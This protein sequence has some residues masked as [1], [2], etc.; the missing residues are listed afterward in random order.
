MFGLIV[1]AAFYPFIMTLS[2][3]SYMSLLVAF[4]CIGIFGRKPLMLVFVAV[5]LVASP[6]IMPE[7]V[8]ERINYT[9]Q[10]EGVEVEIGGVPTNIEIDKSTYE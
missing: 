7:D 9:F 5:V 2:R 3:A 1:L 8:I 10:P 6:Y 4:V